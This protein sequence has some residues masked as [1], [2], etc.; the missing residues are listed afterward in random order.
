MS[1]VHEP[2]FRIMT[3]SCLFIPPIKNICYVVYHINQVMHIP[4]LSLY[5][6][7][8][9]MSLSFSL[10]L[11]AFLVSFLPLLALKKSYISHGRTF[12]TILWLWLNLACLFF[13]S[14]VSVGSFSHQPSH[15]YTVVIPLSYYFLYGVPP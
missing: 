10:L 2:N 4:S 11:S 14:I 3:E 1:V 9:S 8:F 15:P 5:P 12:R 7:I 6:S 13:L